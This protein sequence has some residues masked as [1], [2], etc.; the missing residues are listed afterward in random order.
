MSCI[1]IDDETDGL[2]LLATLIGKHC[3]ELHIIGR[4]DNPWT[5]IQAIRTLSPDLVFLDVEMPEINGFGV[6]EAC[7]DLSFQVIFTTAFSQYAVRAFKYSAIGYLLKPIDEEDLK[8]A[9]QKAKSLQ[10][11]HD[12]HAQQ[13]D[14]LFDGLHPT[15]PRHDK[16][17]LPTA[18]GLA[19]LTIQDI[20]YCKADGNYTD[21]WLRNQPKKQ[22][23]TKL[24]KY[25]EELL[26]TDVF[27]RVHHSYLINLQQ[28][29]Q[30]IKG[31][32]G[33]V[34]MSNGDLVPVAR[35]NKQELLRL[36]E[37]I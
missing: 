23:F 16:I 25:I 18:D 30:Y 35:P 11:I 24:L 34:K 27:Y 2:H 9:V 3:P 4:Y 12:Y 22:T 28:V 10:T 13:R 7:R 5:G 17:A 20:V 37:S 26:P 31:E 32:G 14:I 21:I 29:E 33:E 15:Q 1:L 6:L 8:E 36:L 19:F